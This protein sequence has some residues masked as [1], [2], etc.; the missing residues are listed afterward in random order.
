M[1]L[2]RGVIATILCSGCG[3]PEDLNCTKNPEYHAAKKG[4]VNTEEK[5]YLCPLCSSIKERQS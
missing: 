4:W 2:K 1:E 3:N 5:G